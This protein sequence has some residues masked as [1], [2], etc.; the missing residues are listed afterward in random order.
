MDGRGTSPRG[1]SQPHSAERLQR[2]VERGRAPVCPERVGDVAAAGGRHLRAG[3]EGRGAGD[4]RP[5]GRGVGRA[6]GRPERGQR[7]RGC[8]VHER[9]RNQGPDPPLRGRGGAHR[10]RRHLH[11]HKQQRRHPRLCR[12]WKQH[13]GRGVRHYGEPRLFGTVEPVRPQGGRVDQTRAERADG[14]DG[15]TG[16]ADDGSAVLDRAEVRRRDRRHRLQGRVVGG[17]QRPLDGGPGR[18][19]LD[20]HLIH[21]HGA[22]ATDD[23]PLPRLG[24]Q[25]GGRRRGLRERERNHTGVAGGDH[26]GIRRHRRESGD[27]GH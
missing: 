20:L 12:D 16:D 2:T 8:K 1:H 15:G 21:P 14:A 17:R 11:P 6:G 22:H 18:H 19:R 3:R 27:R 13:H 25:F 7:L 10:H 23:L 9:Q 26:L 5:G 24:H 4:L